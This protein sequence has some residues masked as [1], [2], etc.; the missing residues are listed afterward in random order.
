MLTQTAPSPDELSS[1]PSLAV[2][3]PIRLAE[4]NP[5]AI[6]AVW[7]K[8]ERH[9]LSVIDRLDGRYTVAAMRA[10]LE[11]GETVLWL[12]GQTTADG[13]AVVHAVMGTDIAKTPAG[14]LTARV[15]WMTG[16][17]RGKWVHL[18]GDYE[19]AMRKR[20]CNRVEI[21]ARKGWAKELAD[22][23]LTHVQLEKDL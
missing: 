7:P 12:A 22:Y 9:L 20:G 5:A 21:T 2:D 10:A 3:G 11:A 13:R 14:T 15:L 6:G 23:K 19:A 18:L 16:V 4:V 8:V 17:D 1:S